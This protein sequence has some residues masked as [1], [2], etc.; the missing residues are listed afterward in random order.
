[1]LK[2]IYFRICLEGDFLD[3]ESIA[4]EISTHHV[5]LRHVLIR[6]I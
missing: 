6:E 1:M 3:E 5:F 4:L 2:R